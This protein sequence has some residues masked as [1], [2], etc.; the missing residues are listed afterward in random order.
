LPVEKSRSPAFR[1]WT[2]EAPAAGI[3][4]LQAARIRELP[5]PD[6]ARLE[7]LH[8]PDSHSQNALADERVCVFRLHWRG[9]KLLLTSDAGMGTELE[10][11]AS[12]RDLRADVIIAGHHRTDASLS[13]R[14]LE[15]V[16][17]QAIIASHADFPVAEKLDAA[18]V[19]YWKSRGI[20]VIHQ[21]ESGGVT[22]RVN[23]DGNLR[24]EGFADHS[25]TVLKRR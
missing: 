16:D 7:I 3:V 4:T 12:G 17:P 8:V 23:E 18:A 6:G 11:L 14:F 13:D 2:T 22:I 5:L 20:R 19:A 21:G 10:M 9:W 24:L 15:A 25:V 1:A